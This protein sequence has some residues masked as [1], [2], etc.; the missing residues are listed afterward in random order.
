MTK[1]LQQGNPDSHSFQPYSIKKDVKNNDKQKQGLCFDIKNLK[2][3]DQSHLENFS[4]N[5]SSH[6]Y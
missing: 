1:C 3:C 2:A 5:Q 6:K 4:T